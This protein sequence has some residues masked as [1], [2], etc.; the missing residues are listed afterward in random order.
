[1]ASILS[2]CY[3]LSISSLGVSEIWLG[4]EILRQKFQVILEIMHGLCE[5]CIC[6]ISCYL[7]H[8]T[9]QTVVILYHSTFIYVTYLCY[10]CTVKPFIYLNLSTIL[11][12]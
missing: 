8:D 1:M 3:V 2:T 11:L 7:H 10:V 4:L 12:I 5:P 6:I 9:K